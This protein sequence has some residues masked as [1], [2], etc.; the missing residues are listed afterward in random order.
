MVAEYIQDILQASEI[1]ATIGELPSTRNNACAINEYASGVSTEY[2]G[3]RTG[4]SIFNPIAKVVVRNQSYLD[5]MTLI[6]RVSA[7]LHRYSDDTLL[8]V[9]LV[10]SALYLGKNT[11]QMHEF[12]ATFNIQVKE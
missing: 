2:F 9:L 6:E 5:G 8:S 3:D 10:G 7:I 11:D 4:S 12:Q 1:P